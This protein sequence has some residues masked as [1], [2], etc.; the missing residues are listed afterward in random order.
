VGQRVRFGGAENR[1]WDVIVGVVGDV[2]QASLAADR[3]DAFYVAT[4]QWLWADPAMWVVVS[5]NGDATALAHAVRDA[6]WSADRDQPIVRAGSLDDLVRASEAQRRFALTIFEAFALAALALAAI[7]IY[8]VLAASVVE[9]TR[10]IGVRSALGAS[11][12]AIVGLVAQQALML[13]VIG[14]GIGLAGGAFASRA[15]AA[16]LFGVTRTDPATYAGVV[17]VVTAVAAAASLVPAWRA[18]RI[19]PAITLRT[20]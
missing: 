12:R 6:I 14:S 3:T 4:D 11:R 19:D 17:L 18:A 9:R 2:R 16:L 15:I 7:G 5:A 13:T 8:G 20:Q 1:P 10:E